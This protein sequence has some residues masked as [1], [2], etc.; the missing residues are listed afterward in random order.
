M[1]N[2]VYS[3]K[4]SPDLISH[5]RASPIPRLDSY[6]LPRMSTDPRVKT[7]RF[8]L[9][10]NRQLYVQ[11]R[12]VGQPQG[13][14]LPYFRVHLYF[15]VSLLRPQLYVRSTYMSS[16]TPPD[17]PVPFDNLIKA[18]VWVLREP[19][20]VSVASAWFGADTYNTQGRVG[21]RCNRHLFGIRAYCYHEHKVLRSQ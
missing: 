21:G 9:W 2:T 18:I 10:S 17:R 1:R 16:D 7:T 4:A 11:V 6:P 12:H 15:A 19:W 14:I 3:L 20:R 8:Y 5:P 13:E